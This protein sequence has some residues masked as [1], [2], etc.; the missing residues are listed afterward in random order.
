MPELVVIFVG[1]RLNSENLPIDERYV[2]GSIK[3]NTDR[4]PETQEDF[5]EIAK[6]IGRNGDYASVGVKQV[7]YDDEGLFSKLPKPGSVA[8]NLSEKKTATM[9]EI[10]QGEVVDE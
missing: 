9:D 3:I 4:E 10:I 8:T 1:E 6:A 5:N 2:E 7:L